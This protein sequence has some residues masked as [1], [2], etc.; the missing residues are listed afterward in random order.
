VSL[1]GVLDAI[2]A[3]S[4][5]EIDYDWTNP[6]NRFSEVTSAFD[7]LEESVT[8]FKNSVGAIQSQGDLGSSAPTL[9]Q[10]RTFADAVGPYVKALDN[11]YRALRKCV[12]IAAVQQRSDCGATAYA[13]LYSKVWDAA[14]PLLDARF[15][16]AGPQA[17]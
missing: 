9:Q 8:L 11:Y 13:T 12:P 14:G 5:I 2:S 4:A 16:L 6:S 17:Q 7:K 10:L 15:A 3:H 1:T